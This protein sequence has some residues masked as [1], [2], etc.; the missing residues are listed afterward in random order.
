MTTDTNQHHR[1]VAHDMAKGIQISR[2]TSAN[3]THSTKISAV[4]CKQLSSDIIDPLFLWYLRAG[5]V[6][7][8]PQWEK[9]PNLSVKS[10][11]TSKKLIL[12]FYFVAKTVH[13][14]GSEE[15]K[16]EVEGPDWQPRFRM[17]PQT[18]GGRIT[19]AIS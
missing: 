2:V 13:G 19:K 17:L 3:T 1:H 7:A 12:G 11:V 10:F 14:H 8:E 4:N 15:R 18:A 16:P 9:Y 5:S 6:K